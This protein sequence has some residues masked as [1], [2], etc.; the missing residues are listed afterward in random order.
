MFGNRVEI[1]RLPVTIF[2]T[3]K[4][5]NKSKAVKSYKIARSMSEFHY[6]HIIYLNIFSTPS[7]LP[8]SS[9]CSPNA[10]MFDFR[11]LSGTVS[12]PELHGISRVYLPAPS[13]KVV[14]MKR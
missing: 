7:S 5:D 8:F 4:G 11:H 12:H 10:P 9:V 3:N 14:V 1:V 6:S 2:A 13:S